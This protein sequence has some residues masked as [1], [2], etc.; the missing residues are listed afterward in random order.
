MIH[1]TLTDSDKKQILIAVIGAIA[2]GLILMYLSKR[3]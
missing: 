2:S 1:P 3:K